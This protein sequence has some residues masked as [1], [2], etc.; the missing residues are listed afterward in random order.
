MFNHLY[1]IYKRALGWSGRRRLAAF[2]QII[3]KLSAMETS[4]MRKCALED[5][6]L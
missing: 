4:T 6:V 5:I 2:A 3:W 1:E